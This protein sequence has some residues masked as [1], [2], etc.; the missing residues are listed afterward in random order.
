MG[1]H[2]RSV[3]ENCVRV[4]VALFAAH[5]AAGCTK[6]PEPSRAPPDDVNA[7]ATIERIRK[8]QARSKV[9]VEREVR[10]S[11]QEDRVDAGLLAAPPPRAPEELGQLEGT[12]AGP[13]QQ[14]TASVSGKLEA[15]APNQLIIRDHTGFQYRLKTDDRTRVTFN[16]QPAKLDQF[17]QGTEVRA[18]Y[19][20]D[21]Q[22]RVATHVEVLRPSD[23]GHEAG[24]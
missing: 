9:S 7:N 3:L 22:N 21:R 6:A 1:R 11:I 4:G 14:G 18:T 8:E 15:S 10:R 23:A 2:G 13:M 17:K 24:G 20:F 12:D 19:V 16:G 5:A